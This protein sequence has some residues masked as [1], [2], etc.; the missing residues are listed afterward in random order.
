MSSPSKS[1]SPMDAL[2]SQFDETHGSQSEPGLLKRNPTITTTDA[3]ENLA[4]DRSSLRD[5][6]S[7]NRRGTES[8]KRKTK[9]AFTL[10]RNSATLRNSY[11]KG[12]LEQLTDRLRSLPGSEDSDS[13]D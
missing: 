10:Q 12:D 11:K 13:D 3:E 1:P 9:K 7:R 8:K 2:S 4:D 5:N 6:A